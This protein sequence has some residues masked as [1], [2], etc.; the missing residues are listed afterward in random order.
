MRKNIN[1]SVIKPSMAKS[2]HVITTLPAWTQ[3]LNCDL[4]QKNGSFLDVSGA[5]MPQK[6]GYM[7]KA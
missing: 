2:D 6:K 1:V 4:E 5:L 7:R 3:V